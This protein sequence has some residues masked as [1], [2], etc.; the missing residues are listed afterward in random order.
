M[1]SAFDANTEEAWQSLLDNN[2]LQPT[3][4]NVTTTYV[5]FDTK[6]R[7]PLPKL[8]HIETD[9]TRQADEIINQNYKGIAQT[10]PDVT[11]GQFELR[12]GWL[13][14]MNQL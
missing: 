5:N 8:E 7:L 6:T 10:T 13:K 11:F 1:H 14:M 3:D 4:E 9:W 2:W 12:E